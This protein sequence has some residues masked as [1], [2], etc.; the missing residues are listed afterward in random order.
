MKRK[1]FASLLMLWL[2]VPTLVAIGFVGLT[3]ANGY[4]APEKVPV[5]QAYIRSNGDVEPPTLPIQRSG[6]VYALTN[7][8]VNYSIEI[9]KDNI[10]LD[11]NGY[12]LTFRPMGKEDNPWSEKTA[13]PAI[14]IINKNNIIVKN[15]T[16]DN[17]ITGSFT[18]VGVENSSNIIIT[19]TTVKNELGVSI[20]SSTWCSYIGNE[21]TNAGVGIGIFDS[22]FINL[23]YNEIS[24]NR[25][26]GAT[27]GS[28][29][30]SNITRNNIMDNAE[31]GIIIHGSNFNNCIFENNFIDNE[32][33]I[34]YRGD[35]NISAN[36]KIFD[37]YWYNNQWNIQNTN[38][39][40]MPYVAVADHSPL[41]SPI[42]TSF[43]PLLFPL[44]SLSST[45]TSEP[46]PITRVVA[47]SG[48][49]VIVGVGLLFYLKKRKE[50][51]GP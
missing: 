11:G 42:S 43:D 26:M 35:S 25:Y 18:G 32:V 22:T 30:Y 27:I 37:N 39:K 3:K 45:S 9:Q 16:F 4:V 2:A 23:A 51:R 36:D 21:I 17:Y 33:G 5:G 40:G 29:S 48:A 7:N 24:K 38:D 15:V 14:R 44:P 1:A 50:S 41:T 8:I 28:V 34:L 31:A 12:S 10:I 19:N 13:D 20:R 49:V 6:N 47:V 46:F